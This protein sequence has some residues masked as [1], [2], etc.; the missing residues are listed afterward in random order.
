MLISI[1]QKIFKRNF[2]QVV[3]YGPSKEINLITS[4]SQ[5]NRISKQKEWNQTVKTIRH[6]NNIDLFR[7]QNKCQRNLIWKPTKATGAQIVPHI[8][9]IYNLDQSF[10]S[11]LTN[12][13]LYI[14]NEWTRWPLVWYDLL[15]K[16]RLPKCTQ[17]F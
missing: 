1:S 5:N 14:L 10:E 3:F 16:P 12:N 8:S 9:V 17:K 11:I 6:R 7:N 13:S 15:S 4:Q 2:K